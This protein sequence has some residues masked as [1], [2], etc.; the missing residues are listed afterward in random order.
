MVD[1]VQL[2]E[3]LKDRLEQDRAIHIIEVAGPTLEAVTADAAAL[4]DIPVRH[5]EYEITERGSPGIL[6]IGKKEWRI[7][8]Y[9]KVTVG[10]KKDGEGLL[11]EE[12][13]EQGP[14]IEDRDGEA[15]VHFTTAGDA[16]LKVTAPSGNG[17]KAMESYAV[18]LLNDRQTQNINT[19]LVSKIVREAKGEYIKVGVFERHSYNDSVVRPEVSEGEMYAYMQVTPPGE[20][21]CDVAYETFITIFKGSRIVHGIKEDVLWNFIDKPVYNEKMEIAEGTKAL[22][23]RDAYIQY[24]FETD[25]S[26]VRLK[27]GNN[28]KIDFKELNIIQNVV[29]NQALAKKIPAEKGIPGETVTGKWLSATN[30]KDINLP[31]GTNVHVSDEDSDVILSDMNG[32]VIVAGGLVNVEPVYTVNGDVNLKTGNIIFL[33]TVIVQGNIE[34]GFSIKAAG[35][36]EVHGTVAKADLD[37]EGDIIIYQGVNGKGEGHIHAGKSLWARFIENANITTGDMVFVSDGII[38]SYVDAYNRIICQ[39]KRASIMGGRLRACEEINAKVLGNPTSGTETICEV[40]FDP[41]SKEE[42][43]RL[44]GVKNELDRQLEEANRNIMSLTNIKKQRKSL[45][46]DKEIFLKEQTES[47]NTLMAELQKTHEGIQE[48]QAFLSSLKARG[49]V[50]A[51]AKVYPG[52]KIMVRD[53]MEEVRTEYKAVT[54]V[55]ENGLI[56]M[57][58]YEEPDESAR[59]GPDGYT[60]H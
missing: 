1:F 30:G 43:D 7:Q 24:Y 25:Q 5:L 59:K 16:L 47:R 8:A 41:K 49:R 14:V 35:N 10:K 42:L 39:G 57:T 40:G 26:K 38:N 15:F 37:A 46:E 51:S 12:L 53:V 2:Q 58:K 31:V 20:G 27:E 19:G 36:I 28:G 48:I 29:E 44:H 55:L 52:V 50:S 21:G 33:G 32:Q 4:L 23:G 34:D 13:G 54:F 3:I 6:G 56:R 18:Q 45:P 22:D 9:E 11:E 17:R 60:A